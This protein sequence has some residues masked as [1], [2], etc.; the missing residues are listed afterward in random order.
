MSSL[1]ERWIEMLNERD[2]ADLK[3]S[4]KDYILTKRASE[5]V[6]H[7]RAEWFTLNRKNQVLWNW[8][9]TEYPM[10]RLMDK[11]ATTDAGFAARLADEDRA[12]Q[13]SYKLMTAVLGTAD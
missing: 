9:T 4:M 6:P 8:R 13:I 11:L 2:F 3:A 5:L 7:H 10:L 12:R 1:S